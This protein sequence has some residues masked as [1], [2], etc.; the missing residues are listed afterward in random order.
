MRLRSKRLR[1]SCIALIAGALVAGLVVPL[2]SPAPVSAQASG[3]HGRVLS[4]ATPLQGFDV[5]L[6]AT[7]AGGGPDALATA[8]S[9]ADG[10]FDISYDGPANPGA[11]LYVLAENTATPPDPGDITLAAVLGRAPI[12]ADVV[13]NERTTVASAYAM[14]QFTENGAIAGRA[15][16]LQNAANMVRNLVDLSSGD[17]SPVLASSPNGGDTSARDTFNSLAN[18][19]AACIADPGTQ[20]PALFNAATPPGG[21]APATTFQ[22]MVDINLN[23]WQNVATLMTLSLLPPAPYQ[24][25]R[26]AAPDA[27]T[28]VLRFVGDGVSMDG[29]GNIAI[30][31]EGSLWVTNN[32]EF[33]PTAVQPVCGA[34]NLLRFTPTGEY[35]A[36]SPYTGGGLSGAGFG[37]DI[38]PFGDVWV[39]NFGFAAPPP[40]CPE[41]FQPVHNTVSQFRHDGTPV[42]P[43]STARSGAGGGYTQG[44]IAFP[45]GTVSDDQGN[46][47]I[48][49]C[50]GDSVTQYPGGDP[51]R[52][53]AFT[54]IGVSKPFGVARTKS[55][56][57]FV[58][59]VASDTV[60]EL[61]P[62]GSSA[63]GSPFSGGGLSHPL[64]VAVD[65]RDNA[66][67][68][69]SGLIDI[70]CPQVNTGSFG[71]SVTLIANGHPTNFS[72]GGLTIPWG[73]AVDGNDTVWVANFA[74]KRLSQFCGA[75]PTKCPAGFATGQAISPAVTG[76]GF[77]GLTRNTGVAVDPS[78]NV[79]LCN[80]WKEVPIQANPGGYEMVAYVGVAAPVTRAAPRPRPQQTIPRFTG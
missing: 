3:L 67:I 34:E 39:A 54:D 60:A 47:W 44:G 21:P 53:R 23:P 26:T 2:A 8:T 46:I 71:G 73:I 30:D 48:A 70:P 76:Y 51:T 12:P 20:C 42:S 37:I 56:N 7:T 55:G 16:G 18:M 10:S 38:D 41:P 57:I 1:A 58:T 31:H 64:G 15:P 52:A 35:V 69:N 28:L 77:D 9:A 32:Y 59:G 29:P 27:W 66:W 63:P 80:N 65:S 43:G 61:R 14:T 11:V 49:N 45:Q 68:A 13:V 17:I 19:I 36:G 22:A 72:G 4:G 50:Q 33:K 75:D 40:D 5:T 79:W 24:P 6:Y 62:D 78:G 25:A 74:G